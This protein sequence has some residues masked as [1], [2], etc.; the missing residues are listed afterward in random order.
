[1]AWLQSSKEGLPLCL[2]CKD[3]AGTAGA[4]GD[5][6]LIP[7]WGRSPGGGRVTHSSLLASHEQ[8]SL[9]G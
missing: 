2:N 3:S 8:R 9:W 1:M 5:A 4:A 6:R 7:R